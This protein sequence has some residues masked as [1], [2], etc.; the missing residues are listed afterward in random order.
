M[1]RHS[2]VT[3]SYNTCSNSSVSR[4]H[5][6]SCSDRSVKDDSVAREKTPLISSSARS[7]GINV[8]QEEEHK[9]K[10]FQSIKVPESNDSNPV[11]VILS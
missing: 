6:E 4:E 2:L 8:S 9:A 10:D 5:E 11:C 7:E 1:V 3:Y